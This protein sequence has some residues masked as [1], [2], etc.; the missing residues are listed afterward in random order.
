MRLGPPSRRLEG[1]KKK[2]KKKKKDVY[3]HTLGKYV[4]IPDVFEGVETENG[5]RAP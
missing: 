4:T 2:E 3:T 1:I 5:E